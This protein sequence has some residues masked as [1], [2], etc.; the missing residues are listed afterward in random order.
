MIIFGFVRAILS[1]NPRH[2]AEPFVV[3]IY[4]PK[5]I[6][7]ERIK[8]FSLETLHDNRELVLVSVL[9]DAL[10]HSLPVELGCDDAGRI[11]HVEIR[12]TSDYE[13]WDIGIITGEIQMISIDEFGMGQNNFDNPDL[14]TVIMKSESTVELYLNLQRSERGTKTAQLLLLQQAY[15]KQWVVTV[16]FYN[17]PVQGRAPAKV[18]VSVQVGQPTLL[19][20]DVPLG[21]GRDL[22]PPI[23]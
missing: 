15:E 13:E 23:R 20:T 17:Q 4:S 2:T 19:I 10:I 9:R 1:R 5:S 8:R 14:A 11:D 21:G 6:P 12:S 7:G 22:I 3:E 18:I 16:K